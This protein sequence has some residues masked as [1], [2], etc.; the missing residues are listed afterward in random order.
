VLTPPEF[1]LYGPDDGSGSAP[2]PVFSSTNYADLV[3]RF[4]ASIR[5]GMGGMVDAHEM[6]IAQSLRNMPIPDDSSQAA[7]TFFTRLREEITSQGRARGVPVPDLN[8]LEVTHPVKSVEFL[9]PNFFLLTMFSAMASY[10]I[11]PLGPESCLFELW[12][13][14]LYPEN[15]QRPRPVTP[16]PDAYDDPSY[17]EIPRQDYANLPLQQR[18]LHAG[19][20]DYMRLSWREEGLISNYQRLI[21]GYLAG[22]EPASLA[23]ATQVVCSG[24]NS[25]IQDLGF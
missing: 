9:F 6:A 14:A 8:A 16:A 24:Y 12:S 3:V 4:I 10:R 25:P 5:E 19:G 13:L 11:R 22:I 20:F 1:N 2:T 15:E 18:G 7:Q 23:K 21:D 17:P